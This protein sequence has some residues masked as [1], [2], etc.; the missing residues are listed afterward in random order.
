V[1]SDTTADTAVIIHQYEIV[2]GFV[3]S[4][5]C[6]R[7]VLTSCTVLLINTGVLHRQASAKGAVCV[8][9]HQLTV[10]NG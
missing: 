2:I 6:V 7:I 3:L 10:G 1:L 9:V 4:K 8:T 5:T